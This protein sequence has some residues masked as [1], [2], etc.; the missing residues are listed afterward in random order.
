MRRVIA[1][2]FTWILFLGAEVK[3]ALDPLS[4]KSAVTIALENNPLLKLSGEKVN[5]AQTEIP[6]AKSALYPS[7][8]AVVADSRT[9]DA[10]SGGT[11]KFSG[12]PYS[13]YSSSIKLNQVL[14]QK[15]SLSAIDAADKDIQL[16]KLDVDISRR[17]LLASVIQTYFQ[18]LLDEKN[19]TILQG[20]EKIAKETVQVAAKRER[21]GRGQLLDSLQARTQLELLHGQLNTAENDLQIAKAKLATFL[22]RNQSAESRL[23][24]VELTELP[25]VGDVERQLLRGEKPVPEIIKEEVSLQRIE[26]ERQ[27]LKGQN[28]PSLGFIGSY[29]FNSLNDSDLF[30]SDATSWTLGLQLSIPLFSGFSS[31]A[32]DQALVS[33]QS[34]IRYDRMGVENQISFQRAT[35]RKIL[36]SASESIRTGEA[37]F[38]L[39]SRSSREAQRNYRLA[40]VDFLQYLSV[41]QALAQ[42]ELALNTSRYNYV[43]ALTNYFV[44]YGEDLLALVDIL[45]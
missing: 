26:D 19:A 9:K 28:F 41:Q 35:S 44:A 45:K 14:F 32:Q 43:V 4:L 37:S 2:L 20:Q 21:T 42:S 27:I 25:K 40:T 29:N 10:L 8:T 30:R 34:Q 24:L 31:I 16:A 12:E 15:G 18:V 33:R 3:A 6:L 5:Q 17:E 7:V 22:G 11:P 38:E 36:D 1:I 23:S 39:A 13:Q